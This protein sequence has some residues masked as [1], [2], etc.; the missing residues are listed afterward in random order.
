MAFQRGNTHGA[1]SKLFEGALRR[2]IAQDDGTRLRAA[3]EQLLTQASEGEAWAIN[4]L[5][6]RLDGKPAQMVSVE[7]A[8]SDEIAAAARD[9]IRAALAGNSSKAPRTPKGQKAS[10]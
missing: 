4:M 5:A 8:T 7:A 1:K 2:A 6:D 3:A 9:A 10:E